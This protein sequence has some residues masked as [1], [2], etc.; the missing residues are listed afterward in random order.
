MLANSSKVVYIMKLRCKPAD[1]IVEEVPSK[2]W[3]EKGDFAIARVTKKKLTTFAA[4]KI[5]SEH[6]KVPFRKI[7]FSGLKDTHAITTQFFSVETERPECLNIKQEN[8]SSELVGFSQERLR[9]GDLA[10]NKFT[11][12][13]R[14][15]SESDIES[16]ERNAPLIDAQVPNYFD[17][18]RFGSLAGTDGFIAKDVLKGD[19]ESAVKR[20]I[21]AIRKR[22]KPNVKAFKRFV[23]ENWGDWKKCSQKAEEL[24][25]EKTS[26]ASMVFH[27]KSAPEDFKGA[28]QRLYSGIRQ[29]FF[30]AYQSYLWNECAKKALKEKC[31]RFYSVE[32]LAGKLIFPRSKIDAGSFPTISGDMRAP[33]E[34]MRVI[35]S[36]LRKEG[37]SLPDFFTSE[38]VFISR[39]RPLLISPENLEIEADE[40]ELHPGMF[41]ARISFFLPKGSYA[42][43]VIK[44]LFE[45]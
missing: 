12:V 39:N 23:V 19:Y 31:N 43:I 11:I 2:S 33:P 32:Y 10:G 7:G 9:T 20:I 16:A 38:H 18:Q 30:S 13:V 41:K 4:Q 26:D 27:L 15:L 42:T 28:F 36:I 40:D 37:I 5:L 3:S 29:L 24:G 14:N 17:S 6:C 1:F 22:T 21:S 44:A 34:Q 8:L 45:R 35:S 25:V